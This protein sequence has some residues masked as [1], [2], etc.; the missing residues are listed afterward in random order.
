MIF[1][2]FKLKKTPGGDS[3]PGK[4]G[5]MIT[6]VRGVF[7]NLDFGVGSNEIMATDRRKRLNE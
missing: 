4:I 3:S 7:L 1:P 6:T 2:T 5:S